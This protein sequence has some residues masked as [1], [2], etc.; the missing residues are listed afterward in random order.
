MAYKA[1]YHKTMKKTF[2]AITTLLLAI[3]G[4]QSYA[5]SSG[6]E[7]YLQV[8]ESVCFGAEFIFPDGT[9]QTNII[10][11]VVHESNLLTVVNSCDSI[12]TTT[13]NPYPFNFRSE[14]ISNICRG[15]VYTFADGT[16]MTI[17]AHTEYTSTIQSLATGCDSI[18]ETIINTTDINLGV[19]VS[20]N[21]LTS[22]QNNAGH[23]WVDCDNGFAHINGAGTQ[24]FV[25]PEGNFAVIIYKGSCTDTSDCHQVTTVGLN[26]LNRSAASIYPNPSTGNLKVNLGETYDQL[27]VTIT[28]VMGQ[29]LSSK[30]YENVNMIDMQL[31][32]ATGIYF[33][34]LQSLNGLNATY[35]IVKQ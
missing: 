29:Q 16:V 22:V 13:V 25:A 17:E 11:Q 4:F 35:R 28:N 12:I 30:V 6:C 34:E 32:E 19:S 21:T 2:T 15:D 10:S 33:I 1:T 27:T 24:S 8:S 9:V 3:V 18:V 20:E 26:D 23:Q 7:Y 14:T 31:V 5:Q